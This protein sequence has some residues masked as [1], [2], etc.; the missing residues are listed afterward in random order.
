[1]NEMIPIVAGHSQIGSFAGRASNCMRN[2]TKQNE[3]FS[4]KIL[5]RIMI[6][7]LAE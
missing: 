5:Y 2:L 3:N 1:M 6:K 4:K 7:G